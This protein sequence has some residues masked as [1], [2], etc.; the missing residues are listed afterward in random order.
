MN[1]T[2]QWGAI[3]VFLE[4]VASRLPGPERPRS[5]IIAELR[6]GL[7]EAAAAKQ[8]RGLQEPMAAQAALDEFGEVS[9]LARSF[10]AELIGARVRRITLSLLA[11]APIVVGLWMIAA[12]WRDPRSTSRLFDDPIAH[13][14][15]VLLV[16]AVIACGVWT[17]CATGRAGRWVDVEPPALL[18]GVAALGGLIVVADLGLLCMLLPKLVAFSGTIHEVALVAAITAS[19]IR[20]LLS[21]RVSWATCKSSFQPY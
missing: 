1:T 12:R 20:L 9:T 5:E 17:I 16:V 11:T 13:T 6:D 7:L 18:R 19:S 10:S 4:D 2:D 21:A 8:S 14:T 3:E 15:A